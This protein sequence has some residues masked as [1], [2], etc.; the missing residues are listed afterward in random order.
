MPAI[1]SRTENKVAVLIQP[2]WLIWV[3]QK[4][5]AS[6]NPWRFTQSK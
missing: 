4:I 5:A 6:L 2:L 3:R 1:S